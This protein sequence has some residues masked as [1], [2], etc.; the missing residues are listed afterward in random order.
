V[1]YG[2]DLDIL[3]F[4]AEIMFYL[5]QYFSESSEENKV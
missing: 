4:S 5:G 1:A 2:V 3:Y